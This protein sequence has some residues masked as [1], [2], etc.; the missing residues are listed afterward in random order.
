MGRNRNVTSTTDGFI[1]RSSSN[2][3]NS[4]NNSY[5]SHQYTRPISTDGASAN[6][7]SGIDDSTT[8]NGG[9]KVSVHSNMSNANAIVPVAPSPKKINSILAKDA[10]IKRRFFLQN[11]LSSKQGNGSSTDDVNSG[12]SRFGMISGRSIKS[13][14]NPEFPSIKPAIQSSGS[15]SNS[16]SSKKTQSGITRPSLMSALKGSFMGKE[17]KPF[18]GSIPK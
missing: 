13:G 11:L 12:S 17:K 9:T 1:G 15:S 8:V 5:G 18:N 6:S 16:N 2:G 10:K 7:T 14:A 3:V 4:N